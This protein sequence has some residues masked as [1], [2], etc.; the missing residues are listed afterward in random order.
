MGNGDT[1][2]KQVL[3]LHLKDGTIKEII[4]DWFTMTSVGVL[5]VTRYNE[6]TKHHEK[7]EFDNVE[8]FGGWSDESK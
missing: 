4:C 7:E 2:M 8:W 3:N 6:E 1:T 5:V